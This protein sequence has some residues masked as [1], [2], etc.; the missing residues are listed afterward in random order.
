MISFHLGKKT[1]GNFS[2][3]SL[4]LRNSTYLIQC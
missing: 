1:A 3:W 4:H 2:L